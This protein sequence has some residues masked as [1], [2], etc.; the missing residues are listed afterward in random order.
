VFAETAA[1]RDK[2]TDYEIEFVEPEL[3]WAQELVLQL[4]SRVVKAVVAA[5]MDEKTTALTRV[6]Q[7]LDPLTRKVQRLSRFTEPN[8]VYAYCFC[9]VDP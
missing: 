3:S 2:L 6:A 1:R 9:G 5:V 8:K 7:R 4:K